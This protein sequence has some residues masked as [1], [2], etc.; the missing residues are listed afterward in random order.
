MK[1]L[2]KIIAA[3][4]M[5]MAVANSTQAAQFFV[6]LEQPLTGND[7]ALRESLNV[8]EI[9]SFQHFQNLVVVFEVKNIDVLEAYFYAKRL[10]P[11]SVLSFPTAWSDQGV[12]AMTIQA[13]MDILNNVEC[14]FCGN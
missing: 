7:A 11:L 9:I 4:I 13:K 3:S 14:N 12:E 1:N 6:K 2:A 10:T 8:V 5:M